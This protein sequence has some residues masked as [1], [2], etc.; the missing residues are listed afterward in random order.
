MAKSGLFLLD[1]SYPQQRRPIKTIARAQ[2]ESLSSQ[3]GFTLIELLVAFSIVAVLVALGWRGLD[4]MTTT[5]QQTSQRSDQLMTLQA[6]LSQWKYDLDALAEAPH[7]SSLQWDGSVLRLTRRLSTG[8]DGLLVVAWTRRGVGLD[9]QW[10]RWQSPPVRTIGGWG[11]AWSRAKLWA[12]NA[13]T[14]ERAREVSVIPLEDWQIFYFRTNAWTNPLSS[15]DAGPGQV[16]ATTP[17]TNTATQANA[18][19]DAVT[20]SATQAT[21]SATAKATTAVPVTPA[22]QSTIP[23]GIRIVLSLPA[24][25]A[26]GGKVTIDW[27]RLNLE[28][29]KP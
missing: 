17:S 2:R 8:A 6:G 22:A 28:G 18:P 25:Q 12:Q 27:A 1:A 4:T 11:E 29:A 9:G 26:P 5:Q 10:L 23:D 20:A 15:E 14:E 19:I 13:N 21:A 7:I 3:H 16:L 24:V